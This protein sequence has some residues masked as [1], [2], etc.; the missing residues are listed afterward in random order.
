MFNKSAHLY[1]LIYKFKDYKSESLQIKELIHTYAPLAVSLLDVG[2]G[3]SE[4]HKYLNE[5][6]ITGI[7]VSEEF[8]DISSF[9]NQQATY[10]VADMKDF[11][12]HKKF[13]VV[14]CLFSS[15]GYLKSYKEIVSALKCFSDHLTHNG[16]M[17]VEP[18]FTS[19]NWH[20][21]KILMLTQETDDLKICR[22]TRSYRK[23]NF[24]VLD[25][26]YMVGSLQ[27]G[28]NYFNEQHE[29]RL[30]SHEEMLQAFQEAAL[31]VSYDKKD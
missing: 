2:C 26:N 16:I 30:T 9:K 4:H 1:D 12:L 22:I 10:H 27:N 25:F 24:S 28:V 18:W 31:S 15:I 23:E 8:I 14:L 7:D 11:D 13:D 5:F 29:L 17:I 20:N 19:E 3:T 6:K 21:G